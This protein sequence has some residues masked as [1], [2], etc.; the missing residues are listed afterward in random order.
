MYTTETRI[1]S[2]EQKDKD[3]E[4]GNVFVG[5]TRA[6][7]KPIAIDPTDYD[8]NDV[9]ARAERAI[10]EYDLKPLTRKEYLRMSDAESERWH[11]A[12]RRMFPDVG[13]R[14]L[15]EVIG[16][17]RCVVTRKFKQTGISRTVGTRCNRK[18]EE[19]LLEWFSAGKEEAENNVEPLNKPTQMPTFVVGE[20]P[21]V[22]EVK[23]VGT[24]K[25]KAKD[26]LET[27]VMLG[28]SEK[29]IEVRLW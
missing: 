19:R 14:F 3:L 9:K 2:L 28:L 7:K 12:F 11:K 8:E 4:R 16:V 13:A 10:A 29:E 26:V 1:V 23:F 27:M 18:D 25:G 20:Q 17:S 21:K 22:G 24:L 6:E 5:S 15:A